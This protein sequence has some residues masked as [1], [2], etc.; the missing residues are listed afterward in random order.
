MA[1]S[2]GFG[3][4]LVWLSV[5]VQRRYAQ[6]C[7]DHGLT[8]VQATVLCAIKDHPWCMGEL[9]QELGMA[10]NALSGLVDRMERRGLVRR[11]ALQRD[12]RAV[13]LSPTPLGKQIVD[14][15]YA[16]VVEH[17]PDIAGA[18][19]ADERDR[20]ADSVARITASAHLTAPAPRA[21]A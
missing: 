2:G 3:S 20:L 6:I 7:A 19:P 1:G 21:K 8:P 15:L 12:R 16:D 17:V 14:A 5:L 10:K 11:G 18:L 9:A 13:V 4:D